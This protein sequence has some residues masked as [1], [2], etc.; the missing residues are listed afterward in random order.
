M[1]FIILSKWDFFCHINFLSHGLNLLRM[2]GITATTNW[3]FWREKV[4]GI[5]KGR[6]KMEG[7]VGGCFNRS[8]ISLE[9][10]AVGSQW[11]KARRRSRT[12][13]ALKGG[14]GRGRFFIAMIESSPGMVLHSIKAA[15]RNSPPSSLVHAVPTWL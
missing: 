12:V 2:G 4:G 13:V 5:G 14:R 1:G 3:L 7:R 15:G 8:D 6:G 10:K 9:M 11:R